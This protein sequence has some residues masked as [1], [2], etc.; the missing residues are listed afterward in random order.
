MPLLRVLR[1]KLQSNPTIRTSNLHGTRRYTIPKKRKC[2]GS[3]WKQGLGYKGV[4]LQPENLADRLLHTQHD[5]PMPGK[6]K[7]SLRQPRG[8]VH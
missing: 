7:K 2:T 8:C 6:R 4:D 5:I 3:E 1:N